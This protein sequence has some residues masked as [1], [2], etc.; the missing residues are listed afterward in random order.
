M[1]ST[2][3][4][5]TSQPGETPARPD[6]ETAENAVRTLIRWAGDDP[7]REGLLDTPGRV[8][9]SY[10]EFFAGYLD[11]PAQILSWRCLRAKAAIGLCHCASGNE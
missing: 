8:V 6:R 2:P 5:P 7:A 11:D 4:D 3:L 9:R 1:A 10:E